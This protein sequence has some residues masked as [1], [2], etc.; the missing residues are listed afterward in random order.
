MDASIRTVNAHNDGPD[1]NI[2]ILWY[3]GHIKRLDSLEKFVL[4]GI[5]TKDKI[6]RQEET[7]MGRQN[8][9][10]RLGCISMR[11]SWKTSSVT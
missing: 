9:R 11:L 4:E 7:E 2:I 1:V 10:K 3:F 6:V 5:N 8:L